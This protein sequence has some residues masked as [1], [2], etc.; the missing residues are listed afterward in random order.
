MGGGFEVGRVLDLGRAFEVSF[1]EAG[2]L[3]CAGNR[4]LPEAIDYEL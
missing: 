4:C 1:P 2:R 3:R